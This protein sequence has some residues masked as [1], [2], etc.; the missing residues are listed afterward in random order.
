LLFLLGNLSIYNEAIVWGLASSLAALFFASRC[1][2]AADC[3]LTHAL[4]GF[5]VCSGCALLSRVTFG[6]AQSP[7]ISS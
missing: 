3:A 2:N 1:R 5:S 6:A 7:F 4:L